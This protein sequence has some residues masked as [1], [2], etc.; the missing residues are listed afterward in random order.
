MHTRYFQETYKSFFTVVHSGLMSYGKEGHNSLNR[1]IANFP[2]LLFCAASYVCR[3]EGLKRARPSGS[4]DKRDGLRSA[5]MPMG[6]PLL[7]PTHI[8]FAC[9]M[10]VRFL[11]TNDNEMCQLTTIYFDQ[12]LG[13]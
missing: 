2:A 9:K 12:M 4:N 13:M 1:S 10:Q 6:N 5:A 7:N 8:A 3:Q 11:Q